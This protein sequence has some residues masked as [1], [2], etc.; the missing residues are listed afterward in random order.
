MRGGPSSALGAFPGCGAA[1]AWSSRGP[2]R[3]P[4]FLPLGLP[5]CGRGQ[6]GADG[7]TAAR[8]TGV[9]GPV[10]PAARRLPWE[11]VGA[12]CLR[13]P[14]AWQ[15]APPALCLWDGHSP[16]QPL[17]EWGLGERGKSRGAGATSSPQ[18]PREPA[19]TWAWCS[20][21]GPVPASCRSERPQ[22]HPRPIQQQEVEEAGGAQRMVRG[23]CP[24]LW[25]RVSCRS[26]SARG[27]GASFARH[28]RVIR[29]SFAPGRLLPLPSL[30]CP[31][32]P[33]PPS[34]LE[35]QCVQTCRISCLCVTVTWLGAPPQASG[36]AG[37]CTGALVV[38]LR[39]KS[40]CPAPCCDRD[41]SPGR[42]LFP[43]H[44]TM[45]SVWD[46]AVLTWAALLVVRAQSWAPGTG[47]CCPRVQW[48]LVM[49]EQG[50]TVGLVLSGRWGAGHSVS[51]GSHGSSALLPLP[52]SS[53]WGVWGLCW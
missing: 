43:W 28:G 21:L 29:C 40:R 38:R 42:R 32:W 10:T 25:K 15:K 8:Y 1:G 7:F 23:Q 16:P 44:C 47:L 11:Q 46:P 3:I 26:C 50:G 19:G 4:P 51:I 49:G 14:S 9:Q 17:F 36:R 27:G 20:R 53:I 34:A 22:R 2:A 35:P 41:P 37:R 24:W 13:F 5:C 12:T 48:G 18:E 52:M 45:V 6:Q 33:V 31:T 30:A 39:E